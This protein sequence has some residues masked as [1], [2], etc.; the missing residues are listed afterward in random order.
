MTELATRQHSPPPEAV[1]EPDY[2]INDVS[3]HELLRILIESG[4]LGAEEVA[5]LVILV[6]CVFALKGITTDAPNKELRYASFVV[7]VIV[8][9]VAGWTLV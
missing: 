1:V 6:A 9:V 4:T 2:R 7:L 3:F 5:P 8:L